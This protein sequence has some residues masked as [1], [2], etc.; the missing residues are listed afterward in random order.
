M[1]LRQEMERPLI[2]SNSVSH[3]LVAM[4]S[5]NVFHVV[6]TW[7]QPVRFPKTSVNLNNTP[8]NEMRLRKIHVAGVFCFKTFL[9]NDFMSKVRALINKTYKIDTKAAMLSL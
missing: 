5:I 4:H 7:S 2:F 6:G 9:I 8:I 3:I 1:L